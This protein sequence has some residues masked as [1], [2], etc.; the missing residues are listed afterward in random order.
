MKKKTVWTI[1][2][3]ALVFLSGAFLGVSN[4]YRVDE[5]CVEASLVSEAAQ[6]EVDGLQARLQS[7]YESE[8]AFKIQRES[9]EEVLQDF[10]YFRITGFEKDYPNRIVVAIAEDEE[11]YAVAT[12]EENGSYYIL[13]GEGTVLGLREG[14]KNRADGYDNV[15]ID[16]LKVT[17]EKGKA[18]LGDDAVNMLFPLCQHASSCLNGIRRNI[19]EIEVFRPASDETETAFIFKTVEGVKLYVSNP[20]SLGKEKVVIALNAYTGLSPEQ[21]LTG[22]VVI[23]DGTEGILSQYFQEEWQGF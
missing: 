3:T 6:A 23:L 21:K 11:V 2:L 16:G 1:V 12:G 13:N 7:L 19:R 15:R 8:S 9:A 17:G 5:V 18:L 10:P 20:S 4:V 22:M 14:Y